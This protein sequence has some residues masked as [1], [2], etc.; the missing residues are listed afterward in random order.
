MI[1]LLFLEYSFRKRFGLVIESSNRRLYLLN[2]T[3]NYV[4][5]TFC[6]TNFQNCSNRLQNH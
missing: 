4:L 2:Y 5:V 1:L 3:R 6:L